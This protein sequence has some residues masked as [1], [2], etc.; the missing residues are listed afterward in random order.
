MR[1]R[2]LSSP[3][4]R[5]QHQH[6]PRLS[7]VQQEFLADDLAEQVAL[8]YVDP[9]AL[10]ND[11]PS[12]LPE[13]LKSL[14]LHP[15]FLHRKDFLNKRSLSRQLAGLPSFLRAV[16]NQP[17]Q[18]QKVLNLPEGPEKRSQALHLWSQEALF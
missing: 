2:A 15:P 18:V 13:L 5:P 6:N 16:Q 3:Q 14:E 17:Q 9:E 4:R 11:P 7:D 8:Q 10:Q 12:E 1:R